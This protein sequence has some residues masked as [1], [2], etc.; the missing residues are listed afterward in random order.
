MLYNR[1]CLK[2]KLLKSSGYDNND[3]DHHDI[4]DSDWWTITNLKCP[5]RKFISE[6]NYK[7]VY[8]WVFKMCTLHSYLMHIHST[9]T[10]CSNIKITITTQ[11][12][13]Q[14]CFP[15]VM[16]LF[17]IF[18]TPNQELF[19]FDLFFIIIMFCRKVILWNSISIMD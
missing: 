6:F 10:S 9:V 3:D 14:F 4:D 7:C 13:K 1:Q 16:S 8:V 15:N 19:E 11:I 17:Y 18:K 12:N 5:H 2:M